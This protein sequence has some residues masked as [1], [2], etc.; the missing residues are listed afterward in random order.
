[1]SK[2]IRIVTG[3]ELHR[4]VI[5]KQLLEAQRRVW[6]ATADLKDMHV[7]G[8]R[9]RYRPILQVFDDMAQ[10]GVEFRVVHS[11][12]PS[13]PF[14]ETLESFE[15]LFQGGLELQICP[16]SHWKIVVVDDRF[17]YW[18]SANFTGAGLGA[19]SEGKRNLE[20]GSVSEDPDTV[21]HIAGLFDN[22]WMGEHCEGCRLR[23]RCPDPIR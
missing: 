2:A 12:L 6:V 11:A 16:R 19:K 9:R 23:D 7:P 15:R 5:E 3:R 17:A 10:R 1:M 14:R 21:A 20:I 18:G 4:Q 8:A 22:F 13:R